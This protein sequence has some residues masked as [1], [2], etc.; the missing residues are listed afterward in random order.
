M[1]DDY[2][3]C[4]KCGKMFKQRYIL[5]L[6][7]EFWYDYCPKCAL[8]KMESYLETINQRIAEAKEKQ[9]QYEQ[10]QRNQNEIIFELKKETN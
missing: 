3:K 10:D 7:G 1:T 8:E 9:Q 5:Y 4:E 2:V 6:G